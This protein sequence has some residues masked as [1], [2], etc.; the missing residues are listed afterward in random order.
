MGKR[1]LL[2]YL[3]EVG[4]ADAMETAD[5]FAIPYPTA[6][7]ALLRLVRQGLAHREPNTGGAYRYSLLERGFERLAYFDSVHKRFAVPGRRQHHQPAHRHSSSPE[8]GSFMKRKKLHT[9][10]YHCPACFIEFDV[11]GEESLKCDQC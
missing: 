3:A 4:D 6:A 10:T 2:A 8:G 1:D 5:A 11:F 9:G 7:M